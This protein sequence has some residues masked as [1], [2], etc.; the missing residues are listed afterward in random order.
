M[1]ITTKHQLLAEIRGERA[2]IEV[3]LDRIP[4]DQL[5]QPIDGDGWSIK[6]ILAHIVAWEQVMLRWWRASQAGETPSDPSPGLTDDD[7]ERLNTAFYQ[8]NRQRALAGVQ[9]EFQRSFA[10][11]IA[12]META[13][14]AALMQSGFFTW[15]EELPFASFV[16]ANTSAH[17]REHRDQIAAWSE[18]AA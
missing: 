7:V 6:D 17:Y 9:D 5:S 15:T 8:A 18:A 4:P 12:A 16:V 14:E 11:V 13:N 10:E 1:E 3:L 2:E